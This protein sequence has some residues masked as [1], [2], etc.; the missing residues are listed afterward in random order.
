MYI[1]TY[2]IIILIHTHILLGAL[3]IVNLIFLD[4][5]IKPEDTNP[6]DKKNYWGILKR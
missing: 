3:G 1:K 6:L 4:G 2:K 5:L